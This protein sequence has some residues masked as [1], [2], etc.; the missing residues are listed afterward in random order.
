M[1]LYI[2]KITTIVKS[3]TVFFFQEVPKNARKV[4]A[5][6]AF[7]MIASPLITLFISA[8]IWRTT[9]SFVDI[10]AYNVGRY[11][12]HPITF[13]FNGLLLRRVHIRHAFFCGAI[14]AGLSTTYRRGV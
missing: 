4:I 10:A 8:F 14:L 3:E 1:K 7:Q 11:L 12:F 5:S 2:L 9:H 6:N 13:Y